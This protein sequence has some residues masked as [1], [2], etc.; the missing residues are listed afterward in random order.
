[1]PLYDYRCDN[2]CHEEE[3]LQGANDERLTTCPSCDQPKFKRQPS[4]PAFTFKGKGWYKDLYGSTAPDK[5]EAT[6][7]SDKPAG[8]ATPTTKNNSESKS[9]KASTDSKSSATSKD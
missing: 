2:C 8:K 4:A 9:T 5:K 7:T 1:M 3:F 6:S